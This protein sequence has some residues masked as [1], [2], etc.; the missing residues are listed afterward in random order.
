MR[1]GM[2]SEVIIGNDTIDC[3]CNH[4]TNTVMRMC[5]LILLMN[6][7]LFASLLLRM[8]MYVPN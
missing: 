6:K 7:V 5:E 1:S 3:I 8:G 4:R 2:G